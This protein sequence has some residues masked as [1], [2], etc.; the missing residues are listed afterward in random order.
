NNQE[1]P[2]MKRA[3]PAV[4]RL[5]V[6]TLAI[7]AVAAIGVCGNADIVSAQQ[8]TPF[9]ISPTPPTELNPNQGGP[10]A[11]SLQQAA[12]FAW[13]EFFALTGRAAPQPPQRDT[14]SQSC[15]SGD[16]SRACVGPLVGETYRGKVEI[17]P[18]SG[19]PHGSSPT[20]PSFG[21]DDP[22]QYVYG[23]IH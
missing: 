17:S 18:G 19:P 22:P 20:A 14:A 21:Y 23:P 5:L 8:P 7:A 16:Q 10:A 2:A 11:A 6:P 4:V 12:E 1:V 13:Q 3:R 15:A 9:V